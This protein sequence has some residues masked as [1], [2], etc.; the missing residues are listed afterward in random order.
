MKLLALVVCFV[1]AGCSAG[2]DEADVEAFSDPSLCPAWPLPSTCSW[3]GRRCRYEGGVVG[4]GGP[5]P[6]STCWV[7]EATAVCGEDGRWVVTQ[8]HECRAKTFD[9]ATE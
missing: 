4:G 3:A 6:V 1:V 2:D 5:R 8:K 9:A 7:I